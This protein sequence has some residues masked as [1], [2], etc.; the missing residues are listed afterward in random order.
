MY[1]SILSFLYVAHTGCL[2][3]IHTNYTH[4]IPDG[5]I[6]ILRSCSQGGEREPV[7]D[8]ALW[9]SVNLSEFDSPLSLVTGWSRGFPGPLEPN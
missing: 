6:I 4:S 2:S 1:F 8:D 3:N 5:G 7:S 9:G